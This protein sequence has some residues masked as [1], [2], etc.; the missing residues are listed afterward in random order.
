MSESDFVRLRDVARVDGKRFTTLHC[1]HGEYKFCINI[2]TR[3]FCSK[4]MSS[5]GEI[6]R[7]LITPM[8]WRD[9]ARGA[10]SVLLVGVYVYIKMKMLSRYPWMV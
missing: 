1:K 2:E 9:V 8:S 5:L 7:C 10:S 6:E 3:Q 4:V